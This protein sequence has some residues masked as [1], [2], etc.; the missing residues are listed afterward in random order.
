MKQ[1][2][3]FVSSGGKLRC[4]RL[5]W[6]LSVGTTSPG[7]RLLVRHFDYHRG[8]PKRHDN[9]PDSSGINCPFT[10]KPDREGTPLVLLVGIAEHVT[11]GEEFDPCFVKDILFLRMVGYSVSE[12]MRAGLTAHNLTGTPPRCRKTIN[13]RPL[14]FVDSSCGSFIP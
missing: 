1:I 9:E 10:S 6:A 8:S 11:G 4:R 2:N 7:K 12:R 13:T 3:G 14:T 5:P